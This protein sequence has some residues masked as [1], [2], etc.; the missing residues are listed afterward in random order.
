MSQTDISAAVAGSIQEVTRS[1]SS[2]P[3]CPI[4]S[5]FTPMNIV[6]AHCLPGQLQHKQAAEIFSAP[7]RPTELTIT[8][9]R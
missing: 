7:A 4:A 2:A 9:F 3:A 6:H 5:N 8:S 1:P